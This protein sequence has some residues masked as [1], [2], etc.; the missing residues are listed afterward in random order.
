MTSL[1]LTSKT[2]ISTLKLLGDYHVL[3]ILDALD[4]GPLR[5]CNVQRA[6]DNLNPV[7]LTDRLK[8]LEAAGII[9]RSEKP[10]EDK[11]SIYYSLTPLGKETLPVIGAINTFSS[12]VAGLAT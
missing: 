3:R 2:C 4:G 1:D 7:T 5:F 9:S 8:K 12:K 10:E 11:V 6:V